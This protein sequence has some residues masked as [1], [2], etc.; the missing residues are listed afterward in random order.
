MLII[1]SE[2]L[3]LGGHS[4]ILNGRASQ[5][6]D[7][8]CTHDESRRIVADLKAEGELKSVYPSD[9]GTKSIVH[10]RTLGVIEMEIAWDGSTAAELLA[11]PVVVDEAT[12][13]C[14]RIAVQVPSLNALYALKMSHRYRKNSPHFL[15]T[16]TDILAMRDASAVIP[17]ELTDWYKRRMKETYNYAHPN[18]NQTKSG[19]FNGDGVPYTYDHDSIHLAIARVDG[20][21]AYTTYMKEGAAV[22]VDRAK[23]DAL[24]EWRKLD[25]VVE[26]A[27]VLALERSLIPLPGKKTEHEAFLMGLMKVCTSITSGWFREFAWEHYDEAVTWKLAQWGDFLRIFN[28][29]LADGEVRPYTG[30]AYADAS[31]PAA[32]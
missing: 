15:K 25:G 20:C 2:A 7:L 1:G 10:T 28:A 19:F 24:S 26:E 18:L 6:V 22:A 32:E 16:R 13:L 9:N 3:R 14:G 5:D 11:L 27:M 23:W 30:T 4:V 17:P 12:V 31:Q 21:P 29:K 8:I